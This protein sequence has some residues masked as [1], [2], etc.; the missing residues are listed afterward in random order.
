MDNIFTIFKDQNHFLNYICF[1]LEEK[2]TYLCRGASKA[3]K[4]QN[5]SLCKQKPQITVRFN[6]QDSVNLHNLSWTTS[7]RFSKIEIIF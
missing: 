3:L 1:T 5:L 2:Y 6:F 7:L 4:H